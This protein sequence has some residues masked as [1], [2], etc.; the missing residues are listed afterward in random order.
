M[1][2]A[3]AAP[4]TGAGG[5]KVGVN[6][7]KHWIRREGIGHH[8]RMQIEL[9]ALPT[10]PAM[11]QQML[12]D[13][14]AAATQE[15]VAL[16]VAVQER[17]AE[18]DKLRLLIQRLLR[19]RFGR[20]SE[21]LSPDQLQF[22]LED[23]EQTIA[24][25]EAAQEAAA[26]SDQQR[27]KRRAARPQRNHGAL[28]SHLPRYEVVIDIAHDACPCCG[29]VLHAIGELRTEQLDI[30]PVAIARPGD[31]PSALCLPRLRRRRCRGACAGAADRW[32]H[33][34]RGAGHP[35]GGQQI[36]RL[37][38]AVSAVADAGAPGHHAWIVRRSSNWVG[39]ACWWLTPLYD[40]VVNAVLVHQDLC[41]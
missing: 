9:A 6:R 14:V 36:L 27:Q 8:S 17:E 10:D 41:R 20:R 40:L 31:A 29:G 21:Q 2:R 15:Q 35:C 19:H 23:L 12:R 3:S 28:P 33:G 24:E 32:R 39:R 34:D 5:L 7:T 37:S 22:G 30:V 16:Q 18:N 11:L 1:A 4:Q 26:Q 25:E 38:A 13:L